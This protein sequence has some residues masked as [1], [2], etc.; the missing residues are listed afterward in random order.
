VIRRD[1]RGLLSFFA[2][3]VGRRGKGIYYIFLNKYIESLEYRERVFP[4]LGLRHSI[5]SQFYLPSQNIWSDWK[6]GIRHMPNTTHDLLTTKEA[7][8]LA[9]FHPD[10]FRM[11][12]RKGE[13]PQFEIDLR[14]YVRYRRADVVKWCRDWWAEKDARDA[15]RRFLKMNPG[16]RL[17][18]RG[19]ILA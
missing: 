1:L 3:P 14:G 7:A 15:R 2:P 16:A 19:N 10:Y 13:G 9:M 8:A 18:D 11:L 4:S 12:R 6:E 17:A 5:F